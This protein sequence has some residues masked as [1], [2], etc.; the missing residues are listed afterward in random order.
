MTCS[1]GGSRWKFVL[2]LAVVGVVAAGASAEEGEVAFARRL[3]ADRD[4]R[5]GKYPLTVKLI[6]QGGAGKSA[7]VTLSIVCG[8]G[9][10]IAGK[11]CPLIEGKEL[12]AQVNV[13]ATWP[14]DR[15]IKHALV[16][17]IVPKLPAKGALTITFAHKAPPT[18]PKSRHRIR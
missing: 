18:A 4:L 11:L 9:D 1:I 6:G 2:I 3:A 8:E 7:P 5:R 12:P 15:S 13:L 10:Y 17:L 14:G 16:S